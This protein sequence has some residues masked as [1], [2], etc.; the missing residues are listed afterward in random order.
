M[1]RS[2]NEFADIIDN[3][4]NRY[5]PVAP[6]LLLEFLDGVDGL[7]PI[8]VF[9]VSGYDSTTRNRLMKRKKRQCTP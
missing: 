1:F 6:V 2:T 3:V 9:A 4:F 8:A 7:F 5:L